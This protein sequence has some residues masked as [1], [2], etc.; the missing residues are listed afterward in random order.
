MNVRIAQAW[1]S[2]QFPS[3]N[4]LRNIFKPTKTKVFKACV[5]SVLLY[6]SESWTLNISQKKRLDGTYTRLLR[7]AFDISL[8]NHPTIAE[9]YSKLPR[10]AVLSFQIMMNL[11]ENS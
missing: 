8:R 3:Q 9:I 7:S 6:G 1:N 10:N 11:L 5:E 4:S 2:L